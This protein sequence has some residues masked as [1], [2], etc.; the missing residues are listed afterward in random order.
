MLTYW[1]PASK[2]FCINLNLF[3]VT[4]DYHSESDGETSSVPSVN[5]RKRR[6]SVDDIS[7]DDN[8]AELQPLKCHIIET[9]KARDFGKTNYSR[10]NPK[11]LLTRLVLFHDF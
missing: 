8:E 5:S 9:K 7:D 11:S 3:S 1:I 10:F 6:R 2:N 4:T